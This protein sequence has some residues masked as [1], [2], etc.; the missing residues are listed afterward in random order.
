MSELA[1]IVQVSGRV[2]QVGFRMWTHRRALELG[3]RGWVRNLPDGR[4]EACLAAE[5]ERL[6]R[7]LSSLYEGPPAARV[8]AVERRDIAVPEGPAGFDIRA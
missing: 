4:V 7:M 6:E 5:P 8:D 1:C 3:V 2:Q